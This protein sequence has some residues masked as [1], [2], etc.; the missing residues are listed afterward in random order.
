[1]Y[2]WIIAIIRQSLTFRKWKRV[3]E[4]NLI[5]CRSMDNWDRLYNIVKP[6]SKCHRKKKRR[7]EKYIY[8]CTM[9][10][11]LLSISSFLSLNLFLSL[12]FSFSLTFTSSF[13]F[14]PFI[15]ISFISSQWWWRNVLSMVL[16]FGFNVFHIR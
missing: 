16:M 5:N 2:K 6:Q 7:N 11:Y 8:T 15:N 9:C 4:S 10:S 13:S 12:S 14:S 3:K 1:M